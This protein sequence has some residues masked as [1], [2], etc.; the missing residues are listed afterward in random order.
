MEVGVDEEEVGVGEEELVG[1]GEK[2]SLV[3]L[4]SS[5]FIEEIRFLVVARDGKKEKSL[6]IG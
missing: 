4:G 2:G 1:V 6:F 5:K 3:G